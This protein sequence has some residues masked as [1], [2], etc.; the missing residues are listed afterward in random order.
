[1]IQVKSLMGGRV[2]LGKDY[3]TS[4]S[5]IDGANV[6]KVNL[7]S[8]K[9]LID[10]FVKAREVKDNKVIKDFS[11]LIK[12]AK[13]IRQ[14]YQTFADQ[15]IRDAG[16]IKKDAED[17]VDC[18]IEFC[19]YYP[20]H[21]KEIFI[22]DMVTAFSFKKGSNKK[23]KFTS[24]PFGLIAATTPRNTPL[25]TELTLI[26]HAL[27]SGNVLVLRPSPGVAGTVSLLMEGIAKSFNTETL[28][29]LNI[30]FSDAKVFIDTGLE[31][32]NLVHYI[33]STKYLENTL[34]AGIKKGVKVLVDGDGCSLVIVDSSSNIE[35]AARACY[36]GL[37]R[38]N[39]EI[40][41]SVRVVIVEQSIYEKFLSCFLD[42]VKKTKVKPPGLNKQSDMG[43]LFTSSQAETIIQVATKYK[44]LYSE[45]NPL[46]YGPNYISPVVVELKPEDNTFLKENVFGPIAGIS[47]FKGEGWKRWL[48]ENPINLTDAVFSKDEGFIR[49]FLTI[50]KSPRKVINA[51]PTIES[52]FEPWGAFLPSGWNDVS[53]WY[54][55][56]RNYYQVVGDLK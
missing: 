14:N 5:P 3:Q 20:K 55:K 48:E 22:D 49:E 42:L 44:T 53:F 41:I 25:I 13:F 11:E 4:I 29:K 32:S 12:L 19:E 21:V 43:P 38:C 35:E 50:S 27:W 51:D 34:I 52:V 39:G 16:F 46:E 1:M 33:G 45:H 15:I 54:Y 10:V 7:L 30:V 8:K 9:E 37:V 18:S 23:I 24:L 31:Y 2:I 47:S 28:A 6:S 26:V 17:L 40:C 36:K 56:Y